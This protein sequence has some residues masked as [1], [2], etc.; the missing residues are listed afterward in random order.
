MCGAK[1]KIS[2]PNSRKGP[3]SD[4]KGDLRALQEP[5]TAQKVLPR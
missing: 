5:I 4:E 3:P 2:G 1:A